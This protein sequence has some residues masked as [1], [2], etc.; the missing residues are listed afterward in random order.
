M[1]L[2]SYLNLFHPI[3][4]EVFSHMHQYLRTR[5][6]AKGEIITRE[7]QVQRDLFFVKS[8]YQMSY[9]NQN[10]KVHVM[11]FTYSPNLCS[12]PDSFLLQRPS[13]YVLQCISDSEFESIS[14]AT[15]MQ[16]FDTQPALERL[17]RKFTEAVLV[18]LIQRHIDLHTLTIEERYRGFATRSPQLLH[19]LPHKYIA[20][21]LDIDPTNFSKL[22]NSIKI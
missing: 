19:D 1:D 2:F 12:I 3:S 8:G 21:Y 7:G 18:G 16:L 20:S 4:Q 10:G 15:L 5:S 6:Y 14:H 13:Q 11:A 9:L 17:F 22:F